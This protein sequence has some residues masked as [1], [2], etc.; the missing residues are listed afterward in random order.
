[1]QHKMNFME[2]AATGSVN[3]YWLRWLKFIENKGPILTSTTPTLQPNH[4]QLGCKALSCQQKI[5]RSAKRAAHSS[6]VEDQSL[7]ILSTG[8]THLWSAGW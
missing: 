1:M 7:L 2:F 3:V 5:P 4:P 8:R 6:S